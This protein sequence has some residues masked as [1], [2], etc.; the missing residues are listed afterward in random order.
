MVRQRVDRLPGMLDRDNQALGGKAVQHCP[1]V[2]DPLARKRANV[3]KGQPTLA[4]REREGLGLVV[5]KLDAQARLR[6]APF[7]RG[8]VPPSAE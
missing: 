3:A 8:G 6:P 2:S 7:R 5:I 1:R 4:T